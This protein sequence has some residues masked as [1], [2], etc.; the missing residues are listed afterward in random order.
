MPNLSLLLKRN[1]FYY[2]TGT[3][4]NQKRAVRCKKS[5]RLQRPLCQQ[6][7]SA[8]HILSGFQHNIFME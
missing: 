2:R 6:A 7:V 5:T 3:L 1:I 4:F 8:L